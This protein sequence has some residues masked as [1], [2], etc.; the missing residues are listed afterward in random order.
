MI[1]SKFWTNLFFLLVMW[2]PIITTGCGVSY[3]HTPA[4]AIIQERVDDNKP[5]ETFTTNRLEFSSSHRMSTEQSRLVPIGEARVG[6]FMHS[7]SDLFGYDL[8]VGFRQLI[9]ITDFLY[10][11]PTVGIGGLYVTQKGLGAPLRSVEELSSLADSRVSTFHT[12]GRGGL[13]LELTFSDAFSL[14]IEVGGSKY[15]ISHDRWEA[16]D[17]NGNRW[18]IPQDMLRYRDLEI[19]GYE[20]GVV[21]RVPIKYKLHR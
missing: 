13:G 18:T 4:E 9:P 15:F 11:Y 1:Q 2:F 16:S 21:F 19:G 14:A 20:I 3:T 8:G 17:E 5:S 12:L 7:G 10:V 6:L